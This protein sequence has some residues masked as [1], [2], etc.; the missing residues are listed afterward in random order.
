MEKSLQTGGIRGV[1]HQPESPNGDAILLTHGAGSDSNAPLL[2]ALSGA[3]S[4][5]GFLVLRYDLPFRVSGKKSPPLPAVQA[6][7]REGILRAADAV[8][9]L[10]SGKIV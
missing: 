3:F 8:R 9:K 7:D 4:G 5:A 10:T 6:S 2:V 1:L